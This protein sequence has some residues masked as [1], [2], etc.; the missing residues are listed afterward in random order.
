MLKKHPCFR[1]LSPSTDLTTHRSSTINEISIMIPTG[2][3][4]QKKALIP[5]IFFTKTIPMLAEHQIKTISNSTTEMLMR[6]DQKTT[7]NGSLP[8]LEIILLINKSIMIS[9]PIRIILIFII[10]TTRKVALV[11]IQQITKKPN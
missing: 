3:T 9:Q 1:K 8:L 7:R 5:Q 4:T 11:T 2:W 10:R 6:M